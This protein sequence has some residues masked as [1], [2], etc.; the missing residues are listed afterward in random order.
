MQPPTLVAPGHR[1]AFAESRAYLTVIFWTDV[2]ASQYQSS[3][4]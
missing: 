3:P 2:Y 1:P 4:G